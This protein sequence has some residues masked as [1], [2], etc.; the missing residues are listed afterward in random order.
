MTN[1]PTKKMK[2]ISVNFYCLIAFIFTI[3]VYSLLSTAQAFET[4]LT[5]SP[6]Q[7]VSVH[8]GTTCFAHVKISW[9]ITTPD[10]YCLFS[11]QQDTP[12]HCWPNSTQG[13]FEQEFVSNKNIIFYLKQKSADTTLMTSE[14]GMA[15]VYKKSARAR[16][17]WRMF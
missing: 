15:W 9:N 11:S 10:N 7:C 17:S 13:E 4:E 1:S 3:I 8:Q 2:N 12:L 5:L 6:K 14:L 16:A